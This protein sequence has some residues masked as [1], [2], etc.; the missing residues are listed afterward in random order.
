MYGLK[1]NLHNSTYLS[2]SLQVAY[3]SGI[4]LVRALLDLVYNDLHGRELGFYLY[5]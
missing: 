5:S 4:P 1:S 2:L 3:I